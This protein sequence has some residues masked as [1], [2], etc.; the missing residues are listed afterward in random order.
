MST[1]MIIV[2][3]H[4][5]LFSSPLKRFFLPEP[6]VREKR[7]EKK[8]GNDFGNLIFQLTNFDCVLK[9]STT[10]TVMPHI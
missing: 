2:T 9:M 5:K 7:K 4:L 6:T 8:K 10:P 1:E 3:V